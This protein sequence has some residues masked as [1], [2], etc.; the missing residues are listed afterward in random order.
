MQTA[1]ATL[2][3]SILNHNEQSN[4]VQPM[5][6]DIQHNT[7][8]LWI[9]SP[10][11]IPTQC[12]RPFVYNFDN[13]FKDHVT[14]AIVKTYRGGN[15]YQESMLYGSQAAAMAVMPNVV[16]ADINMQP[17]SNLWK[18]LLLC[19]IS[20]GAN[21]P[22]IGATPGVLNRG[23]ANSAF[24][25]RVI[26]T[27][28]CTDEPI[29]PVSHGHGITL[30]PMCTLMITHH[31]VINQRDMMGA[32]GNIQQ[33]NTMLDID[34][35]PSQIIPMLNNG[36]QYLMT[37]ST[38]NDSILA[39][40]NGKPGG[41]SPESS[42]ITPAIDN[43]PVMGQLNSPRHH[44]QEVVYGI[45]NATQMTAVTQTGGNMLSSGA[46]Y[47]MTLMGGDSVFTSNVAASYNASAMVSQGHGP[48]DP[49]K[50][51]T[52]GTLS[53]AY[54]DMKVVDCRV[55]Q[56]SQ[57]DASPQGGQNVVNIA[58]SMLSTSI[59]VMLAQHGL[60]QVAFRY[61]SRVPGTVMPGSDR[62]IYEVMSVASFT[63]MSAEMLRL[64]FTGFMQYLQMTVFPTV[65]QMGGDFDLTVYTSVSGTSLLNL[66]Y[67][68]LPSLTAPNA[69]YEVPNSLGGV[70]SPMVGSAAEH[71][72]NTMQMV[73]L[74]DSFAPVSDNLPN[75]SGS[76]LLASTR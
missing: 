68:D 18:F 21:L 8:T 73:N 12:H 2:P 44:M 13:T 22:I 14:E 30:N 19:D 51:V 55:P 33:V 64:K 53:R 26:Y 48:I 5:V 16:G 56:S 47:G 38:L 6:R 3:T 15:P 54:P 31:T 35:V 58:S 62:G 40:V 63:A 61:C 11:N 72:H 42:L 39:D 67:F 23:A 76:S 7:V 9:I 34:L 46:D 57:W 17:F 10:T 70:L 69:F 59:P 43:L 52:L 4:F 36:Q 71:A 29:N 28:F 1:A 25:K 24:D 32:S 27:G 45:N 66:F 74:I 60:S 50:P 37:P 75:M 49:N 41:V 20:R 65:L